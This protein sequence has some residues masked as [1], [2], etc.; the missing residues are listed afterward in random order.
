MA[1]VHLILTL[2]FLPLKVL[3]VGLAVL[4]WGLLILGGAWALG[5][6]W[7]ETGTGPVWL[8]P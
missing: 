7:V 1:A 4:V 5:A 6:V 8:V 3:R 2:L